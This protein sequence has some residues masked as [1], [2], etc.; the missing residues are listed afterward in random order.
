M[1]NWLKKWID[2]RLCDIYA[3]IKETNVN[4]IDFLILEQKAE[5]L[6]ELL[7]QIEN[8]KTANI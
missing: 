8:E 6:N 1:E 2:A 3:T 4:S 7:K 5:L